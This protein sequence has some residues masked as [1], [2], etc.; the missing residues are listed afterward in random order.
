M[1]RYQFDDF[2]VDLDARQLLHGAVEVH[3]SPKAFD[4]LVA[5]IESRPRALEKS[6]LHARLWPDTFVSDTS[7]AMLVTEIRAAL[8]DEAHAPRFVRTVHRHGYAFR[9]SVIERGGGGT[10]VPSGCWLDGLPRA[11]PLAVGESIVGRD[12]DADVCID[13]SRV[14][15]R[16]ARISVSPDGVTIEDLDSKNGTEVRGQPVRTCVSVHDGDEIRFAS[17]PVTLRMANL[18]TKTDFDV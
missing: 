6:E 5:L 8:S 11:I 14:S 1:L 10:R 17:V 13:S 3:V 7:L 16:H 12:P 9:G 15:R 18:T 4:L 2:T